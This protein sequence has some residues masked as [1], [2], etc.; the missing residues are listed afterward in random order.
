MSYF[1]ALA[2]IIVGCLCSLIV[3]SPIL[4]IA[5]VMSTDSVNSAN[6]RFYPAPKAEWL[7]EPRRELRQPQPLLGL[8]YTLPQ[9]KIVDVYAT[10][11][12]YSRR[13]FN[14]WNEQE[15]HYTSPPGDP[16]M[17]YVRAIVEYPWSSEIYGTTKDFYRV[18]I[19]IYDVQP[20]QFSINF[21]TMPQELRLAFTRLA[22]LPDGVIYDAY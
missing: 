16:G 15:S 13:E 12:E 2:I 8:R 1:S 6:P 11:N 17:Q 7:E 4:L 14:L 20:K 18:D 21:H 3:L 9:G 5:A 22:A 19:I 10:T